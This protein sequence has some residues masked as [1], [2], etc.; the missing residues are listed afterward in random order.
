MDEIRCP[1]DEAA[2]VHRELPALIC[3]DGT[4]SYYAYRNLV[5]A[6]AERLKRRG[7]AE[8]ERVALLMPND[9]RYV[10][11]I[12]ALLRIRAVVCPFN[13]HTP[14]PGLKP[15]LDKIACQTLITSLP[16]MG[17]ETVAD[18]RA[19]NPE[20]LVD[21]DDARQKLPTRVDIRLAQAAT[22]VFTSGS[23]GSPK[24]V[25]HSYGNHYYNA[26]G[27]NRNIRLGPGDRWLLA[28]PLYHVGGLSIVFRCLL[29][30]AAVVTPEKS[31]ELHESLNRYSVS[32]LSVVPTQLHRLMRQGFAKQHRT[33][34]AILLGG[35]SVPANLLEEGFAAGLPLYTS[36]GLTEMA[37]QVTTTSSSLS[38]E[39]RFTSGKALPFRQVRVSEEGE[40]LVKGETLFKGYAERDGLNLPLDLHGWFA[41]GDLGYLD[42]EGYL[43]VTGRKDN[44]F[45]SGGEN[46]QPEEIE[47]ALCEHSTVAQAVVV[48]VLDEE[49]GSR[50]VAFI[51]TNSGDLNPQALGQFLEERVARYKI[52]VAFYDW[53]ET[54]G[55][56]G[57]KANREW[58]RRLAAQKLASP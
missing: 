8:E 39:K 15:L 54:I 17:C 21:I 10:V 42:R 36:Y 58:L 27:S 33:P 31:E 13:S 48:P 22:I 34:Q 45:I 30:G 12:M 4:F 24:A 53:P 40:I 18:G 29:S 7:I 52:P 3:P 23:L 19:L 32:H 35:A 2:E 16:Q 28:L 14:P 49:F 1:L 57:L 43:T 26:K 55:P 56:Q 9:W 6:A 5:C 47:M 38:P 44:M 37:S 25:L 51:Q 11:I 46:I 41:T 50:P 20:D